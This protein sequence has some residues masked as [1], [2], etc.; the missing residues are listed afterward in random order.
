MGKFTYSRTVNNQTFTAVEFSSFDEAQRAVEQG[1]RDMKYYP[2]EVERNF[3]EY[4]GPM[5]VPQNATMKV[6]VPNETTTGTRDTTGD[7]QEPVQE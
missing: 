7:T 4:S 5:T 2:T 6:D 1:I 3:P